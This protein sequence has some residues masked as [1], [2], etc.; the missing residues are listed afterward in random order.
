[1]AT[2]P[3]KSLFEVLGP[4]ESIGGGGG[5]DL[6]LGAKEERCALG[7]SIQYEQRAGN[8]HPP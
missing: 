6:F 1:M 2:T 7:H 4:W 5:I 3:P 8:T